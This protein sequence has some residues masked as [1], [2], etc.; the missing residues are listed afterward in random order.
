MRF[1]SKPVATAG[2]THSV[3]AVIEQMLEV[4]AHA[5]LP[6]QLVLVAVHARQLADMC[7]YVLKS[8]R[9]LQY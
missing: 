2:L 1:N 3:E 9:Q 4:L 5:N 8:V 7:K 6:H